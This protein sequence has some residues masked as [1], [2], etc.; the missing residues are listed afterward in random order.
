MVGQLAVQIKDRNTERG[1]ERIFTTLMGDRRRRTAE[2]RMRILGFLARCV[3]AVQPRSSVVR[4][5]AREIIVNSDWEYLGEG[6]E[7]GPIWALLE[8]AGDYAEVVAGEV[9]AS[10]AQMVESTDRGIALSGLEIACCL[11]KALHTSN[12]SVTRFWGD[13]AR[14]NAQTYSAQVKAAAKQDIPL[15]WAAYDQAL[16]S[17][18]DVVRISSKDLA[19]LF[20]I[21][22]FRS[23][24][25]G[26][27]SP[28]NHFLASVLSGQDPGWD[29][30][31]ALGSRW[32]SL[33]SAPVLKNPDIADPKQLLFS[34][35]AY[36]FSDARPDVASARLAES[37]D[38]YLGLLFSLALFLE[39]ACRSSYE[40]DRASINALT[41][42]LEP[43]PELI[44]YCSARM[45]LYQASPLRELAIGER[46]QKFLNEWAHGN[47]DF[48][49]RGR[50]KKPAL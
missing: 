22:W 11:P 19:E 5:L 48:I 17:A 26:H 16:I 18:K 27:A 10:I 44:P 13:F 12:S 47:I 8:G 21:C 43:V 1:G 34:N 2:H 49:K 23:F 20:S 28:I 36:G 31:A 33:K 35:H 7:I 24:G 41:A 38:A 25:F 50:S 3:A 45:G 14:A 46:H 40:P 32:A 29:L 39:D 15:L 42:R 6:S 4:D 9:R 37:P 30:I